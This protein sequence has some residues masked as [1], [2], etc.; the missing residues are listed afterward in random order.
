MLYPEG[1]SGKKRIA[2]NMIDLLERTFS[3]PQGWLDQVHGS[4]P[5]VETAGY[6]QTQSP[7]TVPHFTI[8]NQMQAALLLPGQPGTIHSWQ[9]NAEWVQQNIKNHS[10]IDNLAIVTGFGD[11]MSGMFNAGDPILVDRGITDVDVDS[12]YF[13]RVGN[14]GF[15]KRIQRIPGIGLVVISENKSYREW[16]ITP[17]MDFEV[18]ARVI[19]VWRSKEF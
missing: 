16:T 6:T 8:D 12:I 4:S 19:K 9:V 10:G 11:S 17:D 7:I 14:E 3:L 1:K 15:I 18:F 5:D 13:F 2:D